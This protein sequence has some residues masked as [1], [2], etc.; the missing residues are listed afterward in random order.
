MNQELFRLNIW[1]H[2]RSF[3]HIIHRLPYLTEYS[4]P[5]GGTVETGEYLVHLKTIASHILYLSDLKGL[6]DIEVSSVE[7][8]VHLD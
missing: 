4:H 1:T 5:G 7:Y 2:W 8:S 6:E 3:V